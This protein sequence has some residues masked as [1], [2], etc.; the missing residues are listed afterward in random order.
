MQK[1]DH[2]YDII[3]SAIKVEDASA[4]Y[5]ILQEN[6]AH[7]LSYFPITL[8]AVTSIETAEKFISHKIQKANSQQGY[9]FIMF[10]KNSIVGVLSVKHINWQQSQAE[11]A[12]F[13][14][15]K[16]EG[17][18][19]GSAGINWLVQFCF[20]ELR[21]K[22]VFAKIDAGNIGSKKAIERNAFLFEK[23]LLNDYNNRDGE[24]TDSLCYAKFST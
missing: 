2:S 3:V 23:L 5:A 21:L 1:L 18:G 7:L 17:R 4:F 8:A 20:D 15:K 19:I 22:M 24:L 6:H 10:C 13:V 9:Y 12:Y 16:Y 14:A 11:I